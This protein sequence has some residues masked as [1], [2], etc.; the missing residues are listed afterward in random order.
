MN[1]IFVSYFSAI[2]GLY[3]I[4]L[5]TY[6]NNPRSILNRNFSLFAFFSATWQLC[7]LLADTSQTEQQA[8]WLLRVALAVGT[9]LGIS[10]LLFCDAF[11]SPDLRIINRRIQILLGIITLFFAL[12]SLTSYMV[13]SVVV[14]NEWVDIGEVTV[15][16]VLQSVFVI[17][18]IGW[19]IAIIIKRRKAT[20][21]LHRAQ[22]R[23]ITFGVMVATVVNVVTGIL[24]VY[25]DAVSS[26]STLLTGLSFLI[27]AAFAGSAITRY[28]M[29]NVRKVVARAVAYTVSAMVVIVMYVFIAGVVIDTY[30]QSFI[31]HKVLTGVSML[32]L[33]SFYTKLQAIFNRVTSRVFYREGYSSREKLDQ[34]SAQLVASLGLDQVVTSSLDVLKETLKPES[35]TIAIKKSNRWLQ[36]GDQIDEE[37]VRKLTRE[38]E[39]SVFGN[40]LLSVDSAV[41]QEM[42]LANGIEAVLSLRSASTVEGFVVFGPR[43][44]GDVYSGQDRSFLRIA[45]RNI[46]T[47]VNNAKSYQQIADFNKTL[48]AKVKD[49][50]D[51]LLSKNHELEALHKTK[52][53]FISMASHQLRPKLTAASGFLALFSASNPKLTKEQTELIGLAQ[54]GIQRMTDI[55]VGMLDI[56]RMDAHALRLNIAKKPIVISDIVASEVLLHNTDSSNPRFVL[57]LTEAESKLKL[58][59]DEVLIKEVI[60]NL[61]SNAKQ[62][63]PPNA[64]IFVRIQKKAGF[65]EVLVTDQGIGMSKAEVKNLFTK[66]YRTKSA[67]KMRPSGSGIGLYMSRKIVEAHGGAMIVESRKGKGSTIGFKIP[68]KRIHNHG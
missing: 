37:L 10:F 9:P 67:Q 48:R 4:G 12:M 21:S 14:G 53:D 65:V 32:V 34:L 59:V 63:S 31:L 43:L 33:L 41:Q 58:S 36:W 8:L 23:M 55:V 5:A 30:A 46:G 24:L 44:N 49:A 2:I 17:F 20:L 60:S 47:A 22:I 39:R 19:G 26:A 16:Y 13:Q 42:F 52:D 50:T 1:I 11:P 29:F 38:I 25:M 27:L 3:L 45:A 7:L 6:I 66:F 57:N 56:S 61:L 64:P 28:R 62:Y 40:E 68:V 54:Q 15:L 18:Q 51:D 35:L